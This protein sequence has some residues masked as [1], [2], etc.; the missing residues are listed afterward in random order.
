MMFLYGE[1]M[2]GQSI[3]GEIDFYTRQC[4]FNRNV[5]LLPPWHEIYVIDNERKQDWDEAV[6]TYEK[7]KETYLEYG[8]KII[9]IPFGSVED[10]V[11]FVLNKVEHKK[12]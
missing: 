2:T 12:S 4:L 10:R 3:S 8:Y 9:E 5:F 7:I 1:E 11:K 6:F